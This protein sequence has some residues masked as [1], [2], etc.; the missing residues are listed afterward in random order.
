MSVPTR[1]IP[2]II[3][4]VSVNEGKEGRCCMRANSAGPNLDGRAAMLLN[5]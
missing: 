3:T 1:G 5:K 2:I 4:R